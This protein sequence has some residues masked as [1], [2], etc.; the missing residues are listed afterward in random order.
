MSLPNS[1]SFELNVILA[2]VVASDCWRRLGR[3]RLTRF[4]MSPEG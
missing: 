2:G 1:M 4:R 3:R